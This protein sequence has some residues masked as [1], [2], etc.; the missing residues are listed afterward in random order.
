MAMR[1]M[2]RIGNMAFSVPSMTLHPAN[3]AVESAA[4]RSGRIPS[5]GTQKIVISTVA[6]KVINALFQ[7]VTLNPSIST[8][9]RTMGMMDMME[10]IVT[11]GF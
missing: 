4:K 10:F 1:M 6:S 7:L 2:I 8:N 11:S 9:R 3:A 5:E